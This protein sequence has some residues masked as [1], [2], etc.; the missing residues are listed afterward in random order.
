MSAHRPCLPGWAVGEGEVESILERP[1]EGLANGV[2]NGG[3]GV[4]G[5]ARV[6][7]RFIV[8]VLT[9]SDPRGFS[10]AAVVAAYARLNTGAVGWN[11]VRVSHWSEKVQVLRSR[12]LWVS[13]GLVPKTNYR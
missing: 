13:M 12:G 2:A 7:T 8:R 6:A 1:K 3:H 10:D 11:V 5:A 9:V 4:H